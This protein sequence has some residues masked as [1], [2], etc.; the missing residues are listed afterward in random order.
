MTL[1]GSPVTR[2]VTGYR[3]EERLLRVLLA[4]VAVRFD[5][6]LR[7]DFWASLGLRK[8]M[9]RKAEPYL[10]YLMRLACLIVSLVTVR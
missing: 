4:F 10:W 2:L 1:L 3:M 9:A 7:M 6:V 5:A 8:N